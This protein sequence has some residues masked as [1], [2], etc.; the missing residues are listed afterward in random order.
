MDISIYPIS[1]F[2]ANILGEKHPGSGDPRTPRNAVDFVSDFTFH[3]TRFA[4][5]DNVALRYDTVRR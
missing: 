3:R 2:A 1:F 4:A 5:V